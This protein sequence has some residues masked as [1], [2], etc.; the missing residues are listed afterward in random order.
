MPSFTVLHIFSGDLWAGAEVMIF[1]L[2][3]KLKDE[4]DIKI[5]ALS[6]NEGILTERLRNAG[7]EVYVF[8]ESSFSFLKDIYEGVKAFKRTES[9]HHPLT[10]L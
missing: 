4:P 1:N 6:L 7:V 5:I 2:L 8:P 3:N 9:R 10:P